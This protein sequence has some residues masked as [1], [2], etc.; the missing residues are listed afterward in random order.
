RQYDSC[1]S[2]SLTSTGPDAGSCE[3]LTPFDI[4]DLV[5]TP[6]AAL[7]RTGTAQWR[8]AA[9]QLVTRSGVPGLLR[10][11]AK[12]TIDILPHQ[13]EPAVA[14]LRGDGCRLLLADDVGLGKTIQA[15]LLIAEL[16]ARGLAERVLVLAPPGLRDQWRTELITRFAIN[17]TIADFR[18]VRLR[19]SE[20]PADVNPW[21]TWPVAV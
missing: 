8:R 1:R 14:V 3:L 16:R 11:A 4:V 9:R 13:L 15:C 12:A 7:R 18:A 5:R 20:L 6:S 17:A 10:T 2:V 19:R 21:T